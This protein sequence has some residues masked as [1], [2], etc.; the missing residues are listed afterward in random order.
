[1]KNEFSRLIV[2]YLCGKPGGTL[3]KDNRG[4]RHKKCPTAMRKVIIPA[5]IDLEKSEVEEEGERVEEKNE[6]IENE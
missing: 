5:G 2:C 4:Y 1:M 6:E 3:I